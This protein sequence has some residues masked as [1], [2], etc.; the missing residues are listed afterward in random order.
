M[1]NRRFRLLAHQADKPMMAAVALHDSPLGTAGWIAEKF[2]AWY[3]NYGN[4]DS[5][6]SKRPCC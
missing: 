6:I 2:W 1:A 4:L 3:G 5:V